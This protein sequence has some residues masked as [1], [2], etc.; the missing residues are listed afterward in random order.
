ML[1]RT[2]RALTQGR[3]SAEV[4]EPPHPLESFL[5]SNPEVR[6]IRLQWQDF[7]GIL[8]ARIC[9]ISHLLETMKSKK[10]INIVGIALQAIGT[11][12][13]IPG[14]DITWRNA[15]HP[16]WTTLRRTV[17]PN[18][19][20][21][22][23]ASVMCEISQRP[24]ADAAEDFEFC[25]RRALR[26]VVQRAAERHGIRLLVGF[27]IE[28]M[29][30]QLSPGSVGLRQPA[31]ALVEECLSA[32]MDHGVRFQSVH[33]EGSGAQFEISLAPRP[34]IE[35]VDE[36]LFV[37]DTIK[38]LVA[39]HGYHATMSPK[40]FFNRPAS[41]LHTH[42]SITPADQEDKLLAGILER[43]PM[44][45][46]F[47]LPYPASYH[48]VKQV[49]AG[50]TVCWGSQNRKCPVRKI[51]A[52][53]FEVRCVDATACLFLAVAVLIGAGLLGIQN[54]ESLRWPD[55]TVTPPEMLPSSKRLPRSLEEALGLVERHR[56]GLEEIVD[57]KTIGHY[58]LIKKH[59][60]TK[61]QDMDSAQVE[62]MYVE[63][64]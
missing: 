17:K 11:S 10:T 5:A 58:L 20:R 36:L 55:V 50:E 13:Y 7:T 31:Y 46:A 32:L 15:F 52:G 23:Y 35:A 39:Q 14:F 16:C 47:T 49:E 6:L 24:S 45:C 25:P 57:S 18:S 21:L 8:R 4:A 27:E 43:L 61:L 42:V 59:Q 56:G 26:N 64:F 37:Q 19:R 1:E 54:G 40:R 3:F 48:R 62:R 41:G 51:G 44:I 53:H 12:G 33:T 9:P 63:Q 2:A 30:V 60:M 29:I 34:P 22:D 28:F 38:T